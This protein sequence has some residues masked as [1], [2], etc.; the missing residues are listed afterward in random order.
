M[1]Y[2]MPTY[3]IRKSPFIYLAALVVLGAG[4]V[5]GTQT[6]SASSSGLTV[7]GN[8][9]LTP[10][11]STFIPEG[12]SVYGGLE[13]SDYKSTAANDY[14][15]IRAARL[16]WHA[17]TIRLQVA[18]SNLFTRLK[19]GEAYNHAFLQALTHEVQY[20]HSLGL[21]VVI[22]DQTE[23]TNKTPAPTT[24]TA[25]FWQ[26][27]AAR[28]RTQPY[29][30]FD[31]FNEPRLTSTATAAPQAS[32]NKLSFLFVNH[33]SKK[34]HETPRSN[35]SS[36]IVW[37]LWRDGGTVSGIRYLGMQSLVQTIRNTG[38]TNLIWVEGS[39][40][41]QWLPPPHYLLQGSN[42]VYAIHHLNLNEPASWDRRIGT[43]AAQQPVVEGEWAQYESN[44]AECYS[45]AYT[46]APLY[47]DYLHSKNIG[48]IAWSLQAGS[49]LDGTNRTAPTNLNSPAS[50]VKTA[51]FKNP[52]RLLPDYS[53]SGL[54][55]G[56]GVGQLL[57]DYF[58]QNSTSYNL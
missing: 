44:W 8:K 2:H 35:F 21:A 46:N 40:E 51:D 18:E 38:S 31:I 32:A 47:L 27:V 41:A 49:L 19:K 6:A 34:H 15:Q 28:F 24:M 25:K 58:K 10:D 57:M 17:N 54:H 5:L 45:H 30:I 33:R 14:A 42:L 12:I 52:S 56:Q 22:N 43:L 11:G 37:K 9:V 3:T 39:Y 48:V 4:L 23:F 7:T 20:G 16:Y 55:H 29:V 1:P 50:P 53:C 13:A 26:I 36:T